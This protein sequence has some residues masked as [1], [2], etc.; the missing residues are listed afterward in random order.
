MNPL[1]PL[2]VAIALSITVGL[3]SAAHAECHVGD[4]KLEQAIAAKSE[5]RRGAN[6]Q[7]VRDLRTLRDAAIVLD[8]SQP[9]LCQQLV[10]IVK[11]RVAD[12]TKAIVS[13]G[14]TDEDKAEA[15]AKVVKP[16]ARLKG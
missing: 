8:A 11:E 2:G 6:A 16:R 14:D 13:S 3:S 7:V 5:L 12:P 9:Q 4:T 15:L 1:H 10:A